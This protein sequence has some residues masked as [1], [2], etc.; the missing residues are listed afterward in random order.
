MGDFY[1]WVLELY[2]WGRYLFYWLGLDIWLY[3]IAKGFGKYSRILGLVR[4]EEFWWLV[5]IIFIVF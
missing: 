2:I 1:G 5:S 4:K 3:L